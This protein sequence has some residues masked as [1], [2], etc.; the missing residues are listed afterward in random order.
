MNKQK[1]ILLIFAA[2]VFVQIF[3]PAKMIFHQ[4]TALQTGTEYRFRIR[5]YDPND[6][7][8]GKYVRLY[9]AANSIAVKDS[10]WQTDDDV[11]VLL[12]TNSAGYA[13]IQ[14]VSATEPENTDNY[15]KAKV[16]YLSGDLILFI[17]YPFSKYYMEEEKAPLAEQIYRELKAGEIAYALVF[18]KNGNASLSGVYIDDLP[19]ETLVE[20]RLNE[21][22]FNTKQ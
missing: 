3:V 7:F 16:S 20:E 4:E 17:D 2:T 22:Q 19:I 9:F 10:T 6:P 5:P 14:S 21:E 15:V 12:T 11:Y 18:V 13:K 1:I 8:K